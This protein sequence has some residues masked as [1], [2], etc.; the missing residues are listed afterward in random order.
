MSRGSEHFSANED[1][2]QID[3]ALLRNVQRDIRGASAHHG[4]DP[5]EICMRMD[6]WEAAEHAIRDRASLRNEIFSG[7]AEYLFADGPAPDA[8]RARIEGLF[9][10]FAPELVAKIKGP[11]EWVTPEA[12]AGVLRKKS[13][14]EKLTAAR[15]AARSRGALYSWS[16]EL[17][18]ELDLVCVRETLVGL[19]AYLVSDGE[20]WR[21]VT[22]VAYC[23]AK[24]LRPYL[25]ADMSLH[26][27]AIL[28][29]DGGGRATPGERI[30]RIYNRRVAAAGAKASQVHF[31]KAASA[32]V[33][34][35]KAQKG[36][37]NRAHQ[38]KRP[39]KKPKH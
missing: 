35:A 32:V 25:I 31:Q 3:R 33:K 38:K 27:I 16:R 8:V 12:V 6:E 39:S 11:R 21:N 37:H 30:K 28:S 36:N 20:T 1:H 24:A 15:E 10:S 23:I 14:R 22:A 34:Y 9:Q 26:D 4:L 29:G 18:A 19:I 5:A 2:E 17:D 7:F 13:Y